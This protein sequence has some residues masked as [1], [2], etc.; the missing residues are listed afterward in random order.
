MPILA[1]TPSYDDT[2]GRVQLAVTG[3]PAGTTELRVTRFN[4]ASLTGGVTVRGTPLTGINATVDTARTIDDY[5]FSPGEL[6]TYRVVAYD[7]SGAVR[8]SVDSAI[9]PTLAT[10]WLKSIARPFLNRTVTVVDFSDVAMPARGGVL[11]VLDRRNPVAVTSVRGSRRYELTLSTAT[12]DEAEA[13][14]LALSF[15]DALLVHVPAACVIPA[16]MYAFVG[17]VTVMRRGKHDTARRYFTLPLTQVDAP[18]TVIVGYT[19][20]WAGVQSTYATWAAVTAAHSTWL[21]LTT[22][23]S[24]PLAEVVA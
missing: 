10:V 2:L 21:S 1:V 5:E 23:V 19:V 4:N 18:A 3:F 17:D 14:E 20:T 7:S 24:A 11:E 16:S 12:L 8:G 22:Y 6:N 13:L 15:G 9:T